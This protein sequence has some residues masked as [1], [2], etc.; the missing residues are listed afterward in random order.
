MIRL[1]LPSRAWLTPFFLLTIGL[2]VAIGQQN[3]TDQLQQEPIL[4]RAGDVEIPGEA[5][6]IEVP[7]S[8]SSPRSGS[9]TLRF[10]RFPATGP[11]PGP[12]IV[13]L[14]GGPGG[15]GIE[16]LRGN[17]AE[18]F[19]S[20]R[21][22][23][24]VIGFDQ[25]GTGDSGPEAR[26]CP[27]SIAFPLDRPGEPHSWIDLLRASVAACV[28]SLRALG[29]DADGFTTAE[30]AD[31]LEALR[32]ALGAERLA[33]VGSSYGTHLALA[34]ARRHPESVDRMVLAGVEGPDHTLK[35]PSNV[36]ANLERLSS[37]IRRDATYGALLSDPLATLDSLL[38]GL[39]REPARV[40]ILPGIDVTV[41]RWDLQAF[42][43]EGM[44]SLDEL[45][46]LPARILTMSRGDFTELARWAYDRRRP[47]P[48]QLMSI[49]MDC[50][51]YASSRRLER[52]RR[53]AQETLLGATI[54]YPLPGIC[55]VRGLP[56]LDEEFRGPLE[57][58]IPVLFISGT[59]DG[60]TP[61]SNAEEIAAGFPEGRHLVLENVS[62]GAD[63]LTASVKIRD[64]VHAFL[65]GDELPAATRIEL[66]PLS[67]AQ[68]YERSFATDVLQRLERDGF[69]ETAAWVEEVNREHAGS[70]IYDLDE[71]VLNG[72]GYDLL[73]ADQLERAIEVFRL[74][75][76]AHPNAFNPWD[77]LG[78]AYMMAG[79][80]E[81]AIENYEK[82][83]ELNPA[84]DNARRM[85]ERLGEE[86]ST[87]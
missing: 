36:Q 63:L 76:L 8:R 24:D 61:L 50:A 23:G 59:L 4:F 66:P 2:N 29:T 14:A 28:D 72:L 16:G 60:R 32:R 54:D 41:G 62:H 31:D 73:A 83:L 18:F 27:R 33:L 42:L 87:R 51:S 52:V 5:G 57:R 79:D 37:V 71:G 38:R 12:P 7:M 11:R 13:Y 43:T 82:S 19:Q 85:L 17:R 25:R 9:I 67:F 48:V 78:E 55:E 58:S 40:T 70:R 53:E 35:L 56:R 30:S 21:E 46:R 68:F 34:M 86:R 6:V 75:V 1:H 44:G 15:S 47:G 69:E 65:A 26:T 74:N 20:L 77:S 84:N 22:F 64:V 80:R 10:V 81:R 49:A 3:P 45:G 39:E